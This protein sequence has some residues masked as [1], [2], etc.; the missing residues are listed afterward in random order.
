MHQRDSIGDRIHLVFACLAMIGISGPVSMVDIAVLPLVVFFLVRVFNTFPVWIHG[1]GQPV[2]L[3]GLMLAGLMAISL[4]WSSDPAAGLEHIGELRWLAMIGFVYPVIEH[5]KILI[6]CLCIGFVFGH[7]AQVID[8]FD[9]FGNAWLADRLWHE[10]N[11][12]SGWWDPAV[13]GSILVGALGLH[14]APALMG[15]NKLRAI[16]VVGT[17]LTLIALMATGTR[18]A[19]IASA[20]LIGI[21]ILVAIKNGSIGRK[22]IAVLVLMIIGVGALAA[23]QFKDAIGERIEL[24]QSEIAGAI[25]GDYGNSTGARVSM[26]VEAAKAGIEH[27][28]KGVGAGGFRTVMEERTSTV[29]DDQAHAHNLVLHWWAEHGLPGVVIG[30]LLLMVILVNAWRAASAT[31]RGTYIFGLFFAALGLV[32]VGAFDSILLNV[33]T[34]ALLGAIAA[35][36]PAYVPKAPC[37]EKQ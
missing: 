1:F 20:A 4:L 31:N 6:A 11:R 27:P 19:W 18:G 26:G 2:V 13:G 23:T 14:L 29:F 37:K 3:V 16:G 12:I 25:D 17:G 21:G 9:G 33:H 24:A 28:I 36:S 34:A 10:P 30:L 7:G 15:K 5:R 32:L 8:A 35:L 22:S